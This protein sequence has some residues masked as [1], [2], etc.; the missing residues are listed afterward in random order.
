MK[1]TVVIT[2]AAGVL[3]GEISTFFAEKGYNVAMLD[4]NGELVGSFA[5]TLS[6]RGFSV[7]G[8]KANVLDKDSLIAAREA[9]LNDFG[10][11]DILINGAGGNSP[12]ATTNDEEYD[13]EG[14]K[15]FFALTPDGVNFVFNLNFLGTFL[16]TQVFAEDMAK[17]KK[18]NIVNISS[19]NAYRPL[20]KIPAYSGAKAA[21]SNFTQYLAVYFAKSGLRVNAI[22]PGFFA[23]NQNK[24]LLFN[25]DG[26]LTARSEKILKGTP[27]G[28]FGVP[29]E[30][31]GTIGY[32]VDDDKSGFVTG[33]VI[34]IDGGFS[35]YSGV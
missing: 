13:A 3:C 8:Y 35:A 11:V 17:A 14:A 34:P 9:V 30:L 12:K 33:I 28:R 6:A 21:V 26:S 18:G 2:G 31:L 4:I 25:E 27:M 15:N 22:A 1:K 5:E 19:M 32:L 10:S 7:K 29:K 23:T 24:T 16:T 20:T